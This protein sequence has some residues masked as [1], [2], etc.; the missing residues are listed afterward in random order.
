MTNKTITTKTKTGILTCFAKE[1]GIRN[2]LTL[3]VIFRMWSEQEVIHKGF[4]VSDLAFTTGEPVLFIG[5][6]NHEV[7]TRLTYKGTDCSNINKIFEIIQLCDKYYI[8]LSFPDTPPQCYLDL[9][10]PNPYVQAAA[11]TK[12]LISE[13][14]QRK[15]VN[16]DFMKIYKE[17][18]MILINGALD[19]KDKQQFMALVEEWKN[20][21]QS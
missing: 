12:R 2:S 19:Q 10:E 3:G 7:P 17:A 20:F 21:D 6:D 18:L 9:C 4:F 8:Y 1:Y 16:Y 14:E 11:V 15:T 13:L 5:P